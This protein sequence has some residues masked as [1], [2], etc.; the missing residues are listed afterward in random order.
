MTVRKIDLLKKIYDRNHEN[1][2][3]LIKVSINR[4]IDI[5]NDL[6]P[7][8]LRKRD[9]DQD[10]ISYL[11]DCS[12]DIPLRYGIEL[13]IFCPAEI[14]DSVKEDRV[15]A[16]IKT[17]CNLMML[18]F[19]NKLVESYKISAVYM[20][21]FITL[22][23]IAFTIGPKMPVSIIT[24]TFLEGV[25]IGGWVFLWEAIALIFIKNKKTR[26]LYKRHSRLEN[27][28]VYYFDS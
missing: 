8:P 14:R 16:G 10:F 6:D 1:G 12:S 9:L 7:S 4:Y 27:A 11:E 13:H 24:E 2:S 18:T 28:P 5:F 17:Y 3:F 26:T 25:S 22:M 15:R 19:K 20:I 23:S 21:V